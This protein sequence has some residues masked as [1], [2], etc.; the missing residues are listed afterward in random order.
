MASAAALPPPVA[1]TASG[2]RQPRGIGPPPT[3]ATP[4]VRLQY[5]HLPVAPLRRERRAGG[6]HLA[7]QPHEGEA[8]SDQ[9]VTC[10]P[11]PVDLPG[12]IR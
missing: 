1:S 10:L 6:G 7:Q 8:V 5:N 9:Q 4:H 3:K 12:E 11:Q 2:V